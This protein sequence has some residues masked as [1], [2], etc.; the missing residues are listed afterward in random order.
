MS[1]VNWPHAGPWSSTLGPISVLLLSRS[2]GWTAI[3]GWVCV[4]VREVYLL[5]FGN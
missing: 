4:T 5:S 1:L 3:G 2:P